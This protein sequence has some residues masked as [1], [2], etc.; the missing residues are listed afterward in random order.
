MT[1]IPH[2][3]IPA[4]SILLHTVPA[5][6]IGGFAGAP[7]SPGG[8]V[9]GTL[10]PTPLK[11][12][13]ANRRPRIV[14]V[15]RVEQPTVTKV[16]ALSLGRRWRSGCAPALSI[17][18]TIGPM[19]VRSPSLKRHAIFAFRRLLLH[20]TLQTIYAEGSAQ[21]QTRQT[22]VLAAIPARCI[23]DGSVRTAT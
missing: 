21:Q 3:L 23:Y 6:P 9:C 16:A 19:P 18:V 10:G 15:I 2:K 5:I 1:P 17:R 11:R 4:H 13:E 12:S 20:G 22:L 14:R 7:V 8:T